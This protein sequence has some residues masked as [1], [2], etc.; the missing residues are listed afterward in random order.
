[1]V[2]ARN[3]AEQDRSDERDRELKSLKQQVQ[4]LQQ[5][6]QSQTSCKAEKDQTISRNGVTIAELRGQIMLSEREK[7][8]II[9][10]KDRELRQKMGEINQLKRQLEENEPLV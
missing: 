5:I 9:E 7:C 4:G 2:E 1:M 10:D 3:S 6:I 8:K